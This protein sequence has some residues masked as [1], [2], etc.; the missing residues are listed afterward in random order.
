MNPTIDPHDP[1]AEDPRLIRAAQEYLAE[2]E[3]G[4]RPERS[5][6]VARYPDLAEQLLPYLDALDMVQT[7]MP[8]RSPSGRTLTADP[9]PVEPIGDFRIV[10]E[11]GRGGMGVVYEAV[12]LSLGRRVA[13][14]VLPFAA[15]LDAKQLQRFQ[16]EAQAAAQLHH[17]NIV[18]VYAV[19][20][21]RGVH[22]YAMQLIEGQNLA[23]MIGQ[24]R[25]QEPTV[26]NRSRAPSSAP[27]LAKT[28]PVTGSQP[29]ESA[30]S[31]PNRLDE[32]ASATVNAAGAA[33][34][35]QRAT[36]SS[37]FYRTVA[38]LAAQAAEALEH[39]HQ[40]GVI[41]RDVKPANLMVD[42]RGNLWVTDF[43]LAQFQNRAGLTRTGDLLGTLRYMSPEQ[44]AGDGQP[45]GPRTDVYSLGATLYELLTLEPLFGGADHARLLR[46]IIYDEPRPLRALDRQ[47]PPELETIV[48]KA[49][50]KSPSDR[51][52]TAQELA[53]D[54]HRF[55]GNQPIRARRPTLAQHVRKW[56]QRHPAVVGAG[57]LL[58][59]LTAAGSLTSSVLLRAEESKTQAALERE[60]EAKKKTE[61][62]LKSEQ[63]R[64]AEAEAQFQAAL[65]M[66]EDLV[67][68]G[69]TE[70]VDKPGL[71]GVRKGLL[72]LALVYID[73]QKSILQ[74]HGDEQAQAD[75][76]KTRSNVEQI[77]ADLTSLQGAWQLRHLTNPDVQDDLKLT[78][79]QRQQMSEV[80]KSLGIQNSFRDSYKNSL[81][82][83]EKR[84][85]LAA[86]TAKKILTVEQLARLQQIDWQLQGAHAFSDH[87]IV[88]ALR[89][90]DKQREQLRVIEAE[91]LFA[92]PGGG[93]GGFGRPGGP[94]GPGG[95]PGGPGGGPGGMKPGNA[96]KESERIQEVLTSEQLA[97]WK[98]MTGEP[99]R[100]RGRGHFPTP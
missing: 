76:D 53:D 50:N 71:E 36:H 16:N 14:K 32:A 37:S 40:L 93:F 87:G 100:G 44:A 77:I 2:L 20:C 69:E 85:K 72:E 19:G 10:R 74:R 59:V 5:V 52:A 91:T 13:L 34:S 55:L 46:Q 42:M 84:F 97:R 78:G 24:M 1:A 68:L 15:A 80:L 27:R 61:D 92:G 45:L 31:V 57:I 82:D 47:V 25:P 67:K 75:L 63:D 94:G 28:G 7:A 98:E 90:T 66:V 18:P 99:F 9:P 35:T 33:L 51:Y 83:R 12:Q 96:R 30:G 79:E 86:Q 88:K 22:Y 62:A 38:R 54:L 17:T 29:A 4:R 60:S 49:V 95:G 70:L 39:A 41:H 26:G 8:S 3:A 6:F 23:E 48:L 89:L 11:I 58:C 43:G 56:A 21:E 81:D 73:H 65:R 64:A